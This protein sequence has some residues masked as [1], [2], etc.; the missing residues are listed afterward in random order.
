MIFGRVGVLL[1]QDAVGDVL[2]I[3]Q[4]LALTANQ[5]AGV[6][7][8]HVEQNAFLQFVFLDRGRKAEGRENFFQGFFGLSWHGMVE[9]ES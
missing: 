5:P 3:G 7:G 4:R 1:K 9:V 8:F 6:V 2:Q